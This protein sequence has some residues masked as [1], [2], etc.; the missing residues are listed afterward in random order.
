[1]LMK[2]LFKLLIFQYELSTEGR[3]CLLGLAATLQIFDISDGIL[4]GPRTFQSV[5][6]GH[7]GCPRR[8]EN[9]T[10]IFR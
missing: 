2:H 8:T 10:F 6:R 9:G 3:G 7:R 4:S 5:D 1:M